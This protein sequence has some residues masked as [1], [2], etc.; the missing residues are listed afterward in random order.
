MQVN[1]K[2]KDTRERLHEI[3]EILHKYEIRKGMNPEKLRR[4][5]EELGP[6]YVKLG[7][8]LSLHS[9]ILPRT[10]CEELMKLRSNVVPMFFDEVKTVIETSYGYPW[11]KVFSAIDEKPLG[12]ASIAQVHKAVLS[13]GESVV[14]KVQRNGIQEIMAQDIQLLR[15]AVRLIPSVKLKE[16]IDLGMVL[17]ELWTVAQEEMDFLKEASNIEEFSRCN[18]E[19]AFVRTPALYREYTTSQILVMEYIDGFAVDDKDALIENGYDMEEVGSKLV[20]NFIRQVME[21]GF[22]HADP[23]PGNVRICEG[24]IVWIDMGMMGRLTRH[25]QKAIRQA[26]QG[27]ASG[28]SQVIQEAVLSLGEFRGKPDRERLDEDISSLLSRY[29]TM[30]LGSIDMAEVVQDLLDVMKENHI[31]LPHGLTMLARG[32][33]TLKGVLADISPRINMAEIAENRMHSDFLKNFD[34]KQELKKGAKQIG[35]SVSSAIDVPVMLADIL[36]KYGN[37][38]TG[39]N[40]D[41]RMEK[42]TAKLLRRLIRNIVMGL[43][44]TAL[45][46][47][48]SILCMTDM[49]PKIW[50][51]PYLGVLG[52]LFAAVIMIYVVI[53][54]LRSK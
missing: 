30:D 41:L 40:L 28:N 16:T 51:I 21:D 53:H 27:V 43:W 35:S 11:Q 47:S 6:T 23:H 45:L 19:V 2:Q 52:Y 20:D 49:K 3:N 25:D 5:F 26:I 46:I 38:Q 15:K 14:I 1:G 36:K 17:D 10:Y 33:T 24:K 44:V 4:I 22:F 48:S 13:T 12:S 34:L 31:S 7:Q 9:D 37:G 18:Q 42:D 54:H 29:G 8:I 32:L 50:G 39:L